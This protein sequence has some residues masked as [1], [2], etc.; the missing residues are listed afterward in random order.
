MDS[1]IRCGGVINAIR[2][3]I[4]SGGNIIMSQRKELRNI[5]HTFDTSVGDVGVTIR[6]GT[7]WADETPR[8][9]TLLLYNCDEAHIDACDV[10]GCEFCGTGAKIGHWTGMLKELP[11]SLLVME[12]NEQARTME[13]LMSLLNIAYPGI[14]V[15]DHITALIYQRKS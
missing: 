3:I 13:G 2:L 9:T 5:K 14:M 8:G 12:H 4:D 1:I 7:K 6:L 10:H 15:T 11:A